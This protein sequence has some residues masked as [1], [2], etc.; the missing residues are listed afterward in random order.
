MTT[1]RDL[2]DVSGEFFEESLN[3]TDIPTCSDIATGA[4]FSEEEGGMEVD[5]DISEG[6]VVG[7]Y[8]G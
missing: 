4:V 2:G 5:A 8:D 3:C 6:F 1:E 7:G